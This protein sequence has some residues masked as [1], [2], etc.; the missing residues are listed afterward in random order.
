MFHRIVC[1]QL[2]REAWQRGSVSPLPT[3]LTCRS[4]VYF[5][6]WTGRS[7]GVMLPVT[8]LDRATLPQ[9]TTVVDGY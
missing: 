3:E 6:V 5:T 9:I 1:T 2:L 8:L 7:V 4:H